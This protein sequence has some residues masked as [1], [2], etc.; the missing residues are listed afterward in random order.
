MKRAFLF[1]IIA[2]V[3]LTSFSIYDYVS[4]DNLRISRAIAKGD[5]TA[6]KVK[7]QLDSLTFQTK[8]S[9][10]ML[11]DKLSSETLNYSELQQLVLEEVVK[12]DHITGITIAFEPYAL[13]EEVRLTSFYYNKSTSEFLNIEDSYDY[14]D[15]SLPTAQWYTTCRDKKQRIL[16]NPYFGRVRI[17]CFLSLQVETKSNGF[18]PTPILGG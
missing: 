18:L 4:F 5:K 3:I 1:L 13:D 14:T 2:G 6:F 9:A 17:R 7:T 8:R 16:T 15:S 11:A 10:E 12:L